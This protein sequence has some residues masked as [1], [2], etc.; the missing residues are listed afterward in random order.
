MRKYYGM[1]LKEI[2][3]VDRLDPNNNLSF[4]VCFS[5]GE[6]KDV[7][8]GILFEDDPTDHHL[9]MHLGTNN[10]IN[11]IIAIY[12]ALGNILCELQ[13]RMEKGMLWEP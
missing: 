8:D 11:F 5:D 7:A 6:V 10:D 9:I 4:K 1:D 3:S 13:E 12:E 2:K